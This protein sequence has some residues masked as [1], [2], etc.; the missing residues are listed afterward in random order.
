MNIWLTVIRL[1]VRAL[2]AYKVRSLLTMLGIIIGIGSVIIMIS[3]GRGANDSIQE[4]IRSLGSNMLLVYSGSAST[5]GVQMGY[6]SKPSITTK[7]ADAIAQDCPAV[8]SVA[9]AVIQLLQIVA[10]KKN[11]G[12]GSTAPRTRMPKCGI[13]RC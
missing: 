13:G 4:Q 3:V 2:L 8:S 11:W 5:G 9:H 6:G 12:P 10:G 7:D 1:A